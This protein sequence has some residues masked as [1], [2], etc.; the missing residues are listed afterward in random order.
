MRQRFMGVAAVVITIAIA[1]AGVQAP[2]PASGGHTGGSSGN[3]LIVNQDVNGNITIVQ[4]S[5]LRADQ[6]V[7]AEFN[8]AFPAGD[9]EIFQL[10]HGATLTEMDTQIELA[11]QGG[12]TASA[13]MHWFTGTWEDPQNAIPAKATFYGGK[14]FFGTNKFDRNL[15]PGKYYVSQLRPSGN[16]K[17]STGAK[18]FTVIGTPNQLLPVA[19]GKI[20][21]VNTNG[22]DKFSVYS[23]AGSNKLKNGRVTL[24]NAT[25]SITNRTRELHFFD[26]KKVPQGTTLEQ[27]CALLASQGPGNVASFGTL[28]TQQ[29]VNGYL[30]VAPGTYLLSNLIPDVNTG[31]PH[32]FEDIDPATPGIQC[33]GA[34][35]QV[36][37]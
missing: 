13:A 4:G 29:Q 22:P 21:V 23:S 19:D 28:S 24:R 3:K 34:V 16:V 8:T 9:L 11:G 37:A 6:A 17:P 5:I 18:T 35:V 25:G 12:T 27:A 10:H 7:H 1:L 20:T 26:F 31:T 15:T 32:G 14:P 30:N 33:D 36:V 2:A